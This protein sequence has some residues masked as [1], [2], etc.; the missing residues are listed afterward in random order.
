MRNREKKRMGRKEVQVGCRR[1][2]EWK[3]LC[4][5]PGIGGPGAKIWPSRYEV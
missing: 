1:E 3:V 4:K 5:D 2:E